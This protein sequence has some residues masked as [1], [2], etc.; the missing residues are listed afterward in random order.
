MIDEDLQAM[1]PGLAYW[2]L[3]VHD[4]APGL[5]PVQ[6]ARVNVLVVLDAV[7]ALHDAGAVFQHQGRGADARVR[8]RFEGR[9]GHDEVIHQHHGRDAPREIGMA[10]L[11]DG[12]G[13]A[14]VAAG[15]RNDGA[16]VE[17]QKCCL[18]V[19]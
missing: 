15:A 1:Q 14:H 4:A 17:S 10:K 3:R 16:K 9:P 12:A 18:A 8:M 11:A 19:C 2:P 13:V 5:R 6:V 7:Q